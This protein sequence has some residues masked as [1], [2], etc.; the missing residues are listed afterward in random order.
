MPITIRNL[1]IGYANKVVAANLN[2]H[3]DDG[4]LTCLLGP[5]GIGKSTFLR[6]MMGLQP[7]LDGDIIY[8]S[9]DGEERSLANMTKKD[10]ARTVAI[11]LTDKTENA[12]IKVEEIVAMGRNPYTGFWGTLSDYD[13]KIVENAVDIVGMSGH[14]KTNIGELSDGER[15]KIMTAKALAQ[16]TPVILLDE[17]TSFLDFQS[18]VDMMSLLRSLAH[19][20]HKTIVLSTH[21]LMLA[22]KMADKLWWMESTLQ[23]ISKDRLS[24]YL[25]D[26]LNTTVERT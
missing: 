15:Q 26:V 9:K 18:K 2:S 3:F 7:S 1:E 25:S 17:P 4:E 20:M 16:E 12:N 19:N 10:I 6:T 21:D 13:R 5:N 14:M 8:I 22:E 23:P 24:H 11:V